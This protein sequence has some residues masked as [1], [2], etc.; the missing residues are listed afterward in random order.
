MTKIKKQSWKETAWLNQSIKG[1]KRQIL[2][3]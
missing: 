2:V 3:F 1:G